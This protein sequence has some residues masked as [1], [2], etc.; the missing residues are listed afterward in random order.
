MIRLALTLVALAAAVGCDT[1]PYRLA[2]VSGSITLDGEPLAG[3]VINLQPMTQGGEPPGPGSTGKCDADGRYTLET[4]HG[5]PGAVV[6]THRVRIYGPKAEAVP[7]GDVDTPG[8][9]EII[10][11]RYNYESR[12]TLEVPQDGVD[13]ANYELSRD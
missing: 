11:A 12:V 2:P 9:Q 7:Q 10:P 6:G 1:R 13:A 5:E 4:L 3:V 8:T